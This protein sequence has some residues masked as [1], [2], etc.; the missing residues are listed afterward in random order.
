MIEVEHL[1]TKF[2]YESN[3]PD[4][5]KKHILELNDIIPLIEPNKRKEIEGNLNGDRIQQFVSAYFE[6]DMYKLFK[7]ANLSPKFISHSPNGTKIA[8]L[9]IP[10]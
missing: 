8:D 2:F 1:H 5:I 7:D 6:L 9:A 10:K 4:N 3:L